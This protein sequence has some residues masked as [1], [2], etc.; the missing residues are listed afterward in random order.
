ME[1]LSGLPDQAYA[2]Y[3]DIEDPVEREKMQ[4]RITKESFCLRYIILLNYGEYYDITAPE[5]EEMVLQWERD[6]SLLGATWSK[7]GVG[8]ADTI[9]S[10]KSDISG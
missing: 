2:A 10:F 6:S 9:A 7:E 1:E 4:L 3:D 5:Y 8:I